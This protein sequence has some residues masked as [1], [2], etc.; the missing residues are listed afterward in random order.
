ME[1]PYFRQMTG[2]RKAAIWLT[3]ASL[4]ALLASSCASIGNPSGGPRDEDP[5][6]FIGANP[7][8]GAVNFSGNKAVL[9][10]DELVNVKDAFNKVVVSPPGATTPRVSSLGRRVTVEF[11]DTL[12]P[13]TTYTVD[14]G[15][16]IVDNN[17]GNAL[18]DFMYTFSTGPE[19]DSLTISGMVL[20][21]EDLE[22]QKGIYVG[23]HSNLD[24]SAFKESRFER[25][26]KTDDKGRFVIGGLA[27]GTYRVFALDD[28]DGDLKW[29]SPEETL[30]FYDVAVTPTAETIT[31][32]DSIFNKLTGELDSLSRRVRTRFLP[33]NILLRSYNTGY[34]QQYITKYERV[35]STRLNFIF[36]AATDSLP[37]FEIVTERG[38]I[39][40][41]S[42]A[43]MERS[44]TNDTITF[45]LTQPETIGRDTLRVATRYFKA[46]SIYQPLETFDTL[47]L[48]TQRPKAKA[49]KPKTEKGMTPE[50]SIKA[51]RVQLK[52]LNSRME[53]NTPIIIEAPVPLAAFDTTMMKLEV[54]KDSIWTDVTLLD[55]GRRLTILS[56]S[57]NPRRMTVD[58]PWDFEGQ[59]RLTVDTLAGKTI[60]GLDT[61]ALKF[62]FKIRPEA[63]YSSIQVNVSGINP[64][65]PYFVELLDASGKVLRSQAP[66]GGTVEFP[67]LLANKYNIRVYT[68]ANNNGK[69]D[70]GN[71][72]LGIQPDLSYYYPE[73]IDLKQN[74]SQAIDWNVFAKPVDKMKPASLLGKSGNF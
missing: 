12:L 37:T 4:A 61:E 53:I 41:I 18:T 56:D 30:A 26:A 2:L 45:W 54:L 16:A 5:P 67:Y 29:S 6:V 22:P 62:E 73:T 11:R 43:Q 68:D 25:I 58:Y 39:P 32:T 7:G 48:L 8:Q 23:L 9:Y 28:R 38:G 40:L 63:E 21:A 65:S 44:A 70:P 60:Y 31:T 36:N 47:R 1:F 14:F 66:Q 51:S 59:Y 27:P 15:D 20:A 34:K 42:V 10:F 13:N 49:T 74:W 35:D 72:D 71:Y 64:E 17:E 24:N 57:L 69:Y 33:N 46:D 52:A 50:D 19:L 55:G 3:G